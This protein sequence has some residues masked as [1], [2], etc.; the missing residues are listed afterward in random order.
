M[1]TVLIRGLISILQM[2]VLRVME[3]SSLTLFTQ[4]SGRLWVQAQISLHHSIWPHHLPNNPS[5]AVLLGVH[6]CFLRERKREEKNSTRLLARSL[7][8]RSRSVRKLNQRLFLSLAPHIHLGLW[9]PTG[10]SEV[11]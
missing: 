9:L 5:A 4:L 11:L 7:A 8:Q 10:D 3:N 1:T 6:M 2:R